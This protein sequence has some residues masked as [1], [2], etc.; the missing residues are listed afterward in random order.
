V[1]GFSF[2]IGDGVSTNYEIRMKALKIDD[3]KVQDIKMQRLKD[4]SG[5][6]TPTGVQNESG[7]VLTHDGPK[8][9]GP[10]DSV[11]MHDKV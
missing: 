11:Q 10:G 4:S 2:F 3:T 8:P 7:S 9:D 1:V 6:N 5:Y